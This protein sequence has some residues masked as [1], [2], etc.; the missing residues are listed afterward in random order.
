MAEHETVAALAGQ[1]ARLAARVAE[2]ETGETGQI[3][4]VLRQL[5]HVAGQVEKLTAKAEA[6]NPQPVYWPG[7]TPEE[8]AAGLTE[9]TD[10]VNG[11]LCTWYPEYAP[12]GCWANHRAAI[13][14][15]SALHVEWRR[16]F[17]DQDNMDHDRELAWN[18]RWLP[19]VR[20]RLW[21]GPNRAILCEQGRC[22]VL[23]RER[24]AV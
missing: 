12:P 6:S 19:G 21:A 15:L 16:I 7:L 4:V 11:I 5:K 23:L 8:F 3:M 22:D 2:L 10:W 1:L 14:E 9:L 20:T 24:P 18:D 13:L 17:G